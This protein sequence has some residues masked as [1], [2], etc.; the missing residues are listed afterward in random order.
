MIFTKLKNWWR[1]FREPL[2][3]Q[4][5]SL[6]QH[7]ANEPYNTYKLRKRQKKLKHSMI[8]QQLYGNNF[9]SD[10]AC[11]GFRGYNILDDD[12]AK[13]YDE[14]CHYPIRSSTANDD[15]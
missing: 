2:Q 7:D 3:L 1:K 6:S 14:C 9:R 10:Q 4:S 5:L 11:G 12:Q 8:V 15:L 13:H